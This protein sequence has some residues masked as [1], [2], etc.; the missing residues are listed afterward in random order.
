MQSR[1]GAD[2]QVRNVEMDP[3]VDLGHFARRR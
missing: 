2:A 1:V 3:F